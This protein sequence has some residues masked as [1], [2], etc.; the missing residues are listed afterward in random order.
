MPSFMRTNPS[1]LTESTVFFCL[2]PFVSFHPM[3]SLCPKPWNGNSRSGWL[4]QNGTT[5]GSNG[6]NGLNG[7]NKAVREL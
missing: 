4:R 3:V 7:K 6:S 1:R 5:N 2:C